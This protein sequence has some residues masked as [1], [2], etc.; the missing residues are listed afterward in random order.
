MVEAL[1]RRY[2]AEAVPMLEQAAPS[3]RVPLAGGRFLRCE[4]A[5]S[6]SHECAASLSDVLERRVRAAVF[7]RGQ[8]LDDLEQSAAAAASAL[9]LDAAGAEAQ[10]QAY[11][12]RVQTRYRIAPA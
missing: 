2:G 7:A 5:F 6:F 4:V 12:A 10:K 9:G 8:G 1:L 3:E 11:R